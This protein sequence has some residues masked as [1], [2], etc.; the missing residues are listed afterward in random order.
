VTRP[1]N[2]R[3]QGVWAPDVTYMAHLRAHTPAWA[4]LTTASVAFTA[5][6]RTHRL[7]AAVGGAGGRAPAGAERRAGGEANEARAGAERHGGPERH[8]GA[9][10][11]GGAERRCA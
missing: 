3:G 6:T 1:R 5:H 4:V 9:E 7:I 10:R 8:G 2:G 11:Y